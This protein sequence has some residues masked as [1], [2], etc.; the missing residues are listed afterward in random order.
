MLH[1]IE[2]PKLRDV[3]VERLKAL[4]RDEGLKPG[5]RLPTEGDLAIRFGISRLSLREATKSLEF[6]GILESRPGRG[7]TVGR[8]RLDRL[9]DCLAFHP[10]LQEVDPHVLIDTRILLETG[11][12]PAAARRMAADPRLY[13]ELTAINGRVRAAR[14]LSEFIE[15]DVAFHHELF[16]ASGLTPLLAFGDLLTVFFQRF[17]ALVKKGSWGDGAVQHQQVVDHLRDGRP[18]LAEPILKG[19]IEFYR[20]FHP[21]L[22]APDAV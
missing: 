12:L 7:L 11:I 5:D 9:T 18:E 4:I 10:T 3:V 16:V 14:T 8:V 20:R 2:R 19:H 13:T 6:V 1:E 22:D 17:R 21:R 15:A